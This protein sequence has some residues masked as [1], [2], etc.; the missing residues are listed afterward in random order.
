MKPHQIE[1]QDLLEWSEDA[2]IL[3]ASSTQEHKQLFGVLRGGYEI[4]I[5]GELKYKCY[6]AD[7][8]VELYNSII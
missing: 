8:A 2:K 6:S 4:R 3:Y 5:K 1:L 7:E